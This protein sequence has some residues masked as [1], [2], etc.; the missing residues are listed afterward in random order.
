MA[1]L[2]LYAL[3]TTLVAGLGHAHYTSSP[4]VYASRKH[5]FLSLLGPWLIYQLY[6]WLGL[7][8]FI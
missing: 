8:R 3:F 6:D 2:R 5:P 7:V 1:V 4:P